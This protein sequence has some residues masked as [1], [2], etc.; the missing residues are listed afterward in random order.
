MGS[1]QGTE[2]KQNI[3]S[4]K[5]ITV[6][7]QRT[8]WASSETSSWYTNV[9]YLDGVWMG[10]M[11]KGRVIHINSNRSCQFCRIHVGPR[12]HAN[13]STHHKEYLNPPAHHCLHSLHTHTQKN[14]LKQLPSFSLRMWISS[15]KHHPNVYISYRLTPKMHKAYPPDYQKMSYYIFLKK[16]PTPCKVIRTLK[17]FFEKKKSFY[18]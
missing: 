12:T 4:K 15:R 6:A 2:Q 18:F 3:A 13:H 17:I 7:F 11:C 14:P 5:K 9:F 16:H 1:K 10:Q 8:G